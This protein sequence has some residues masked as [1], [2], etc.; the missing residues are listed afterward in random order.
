V[1]KNSS[2]KSND[3]QPETNQLAAASSAKNAKI[4]RASKVV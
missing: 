1:Q 2:K 3:S 4:Q